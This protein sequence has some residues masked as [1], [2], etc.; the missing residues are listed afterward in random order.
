MT[1]DDQSEQS[2]LPHTT[3]TDQLERSILQHKTQINQSQEHMTNQSYPRVRVRQKVGSSAALV[4]CFCRDHVTIHL[5]QSLASFLRVGE[6]DDP[7]L[8][9]RTAARGCLIGMQPTIL[10]FKLQNCVLKNI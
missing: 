2:I 1:Q 3:Q 9:L 5:Y 10:I 4:V 6:E 8:L 7:L